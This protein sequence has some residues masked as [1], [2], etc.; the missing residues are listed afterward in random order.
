MLRNAQRHPGRA[1]GVDEELKGEGG[2]RNGAPVQLR[3]QSAGPEG[4]ES[5]RGETEWLPRSVV[6]EGGVLHRMWPWQWCVRG[7]GG[8]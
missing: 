7:E 5:G 8:E 6:L 3:D 2:P 4:T 1:G